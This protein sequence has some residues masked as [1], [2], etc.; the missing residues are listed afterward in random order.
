MLPMSHKRRASTGVDHLSSGYH[1]LK[2]RPV[3][4]ISALLLTLLVGSVFLPFLLLDYFSTSFVADPTTGANQLFDMSNTRSGEL[5]TDLEDALGFEH[6]LVDIERLAKHGEEYARQH[7]L[8]DSATVIASEDA[9]DQGSDVA[10][11]LAQRIG[12]PQ[13]SPSSS[14]GP[15]PYVFIVMSSARPKGPDYASDLIRQIFAQSP[16]P[17]SRARV[18]L[19]DA[20]PAEK[21]RP[22]EWF[23][24]LPHSVEVRH[25][26]AATVTL[27]ASLNS[28]TTD[29][30]AEA[31]P[32]SSPRTAW[33]TKSALDLHSVLSIAHAQSRIG[34]AHAIVLQD[35]VQL[36]HDFFESLDRLVAQ[37]LP[38][39]R[40][41]QAWLAW[42]LFHARAFEGKKRYSHGAPYDFEA[43]PLGLLYQTAQLGGLIDYI[44]LHWREESDDLLIRGYQRT[45]RALIRVAI[46][47]LV[48]HVGLVSAALGDNKAAA[49]ST[50]DASS[51]SAARSGCFAHDFAG[52]PE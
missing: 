52:P 15:N 22:D 48:Q 31:P 39:S 34:F 26:P 3:L 24:S 16:E 45:S 50:A 40:R 8:L 2:K 21:R 9:N 19:F 11:R 44:R 49:T 33:R 41:K 32:P 1:W 46:P 10:S 13:S 47:S 35:D 14:L 23:N 18:I 36:A 25:A 27:M 28:T 20:D 30:N 38:T 51:D 5:R 17:Q 7:H 29:K 43:C 6:E 42:T 12:L 4:G 37:P